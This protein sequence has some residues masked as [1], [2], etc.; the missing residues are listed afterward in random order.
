MTACYDKAGLRFMYPEN[1]K[2]TEEQIT[3][4][5]LSVTVESPCGGFWVIMVY[6]ADIEPAVLVDQVVDSM[7]DEYDEM[8]GYGSYPPGEV[9]NVMGP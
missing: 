6:D 4:K 2:I 7:R 8:E 5:P 9:L 1:W 3:E